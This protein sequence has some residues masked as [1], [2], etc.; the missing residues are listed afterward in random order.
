[1][2][3]NNDGCVIAAFKIAGFNG[4]EILNFMISLPTGPR[5]YSAATVS[6]NVLNKGGVFDLSTIQYLINSKIAEKTGIGNLYVGATFAQLYAFNP[7]ELN[8]VVYNMN[9]RRTE[10]FNRFTTPNMSV[11]LAVAASS[12][13]LLHLTTVTIGN[14]QYTGGAI[15]DNYPIEQF[16]QDHQKTIGIDFMWSYQTEVWNYEGQG[17]DKVIGTSNAIMYL[18]N[19]NEE[20]S[21]KL[22]RRT[23]YVDMP[24]KI[25]GEVS[26]IFPFAHHLVMAQK[27]RITEAGRNAM[28]AK[29]NQLL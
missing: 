24:T 12:G 11:G 25:D 5:D 14:Y 1:V 28:I 2:A 7:I 16:S 23:A 10:Y 22:R 4:T 21:N 13:Y 9:L 17:A 18:V 6:S 20:I 8:V 3:C 19:R 15:E 27:N 26:E 29:L